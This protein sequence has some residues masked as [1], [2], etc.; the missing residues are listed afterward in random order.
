MTSKVTVLPC[1]SVTTTVLSHCDTVLLL[2]CYLHC[3]LQSVLSALLPLECY[4]QCYHYPVTIIVLP[5]LLPLQCYL[6]CVLQCYLHFVLLFSVSVL[7]CVLPCYLHDVTMWL[8]S[9]ALLMQGVM[10]KHRLSTL[11]LGHCHAM[12]LDGVPFDKDVAYSKLAVFRGSFYSLSL[13]CS[14]LFIFLV[15]VYVCVFWVLW[16]SSQPTPPL[17]A[18]RP[19]L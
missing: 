18:S 14:F 10:H 15:C 17:S 1:V 8:Q 12:G 3:V 2:Q 6:H 19:Y 4:L 16:T 13:D 9:L 5:S 11:G 7:H